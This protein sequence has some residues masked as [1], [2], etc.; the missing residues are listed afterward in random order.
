MCLVIVIYS[1]YDL[2]D[3]ITGCIFFMFLFAPQATFTCLC[4]YVLRIERFAL[5]NKIEALIIGLIEM[6]SMSNSNLWFINDFLISIAG[7]LSFILSP[8]LLTAMILLTQGIVI[9]IYKIF[10]PQPSAVDENSDDLND[11]H[12]QQE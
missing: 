4:F 11:S 10:C 1:F 3:A 6:Y 7:D 9:R 8:T 12:N 5:G 2:A